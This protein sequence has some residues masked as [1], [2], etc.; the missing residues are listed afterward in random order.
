MSKRHR[1]CI[2][3]GAGLAG[4]A[5]AYRLARA[6]WRV[7][8]LEEQDRLGGRVMSH[9]FKEAPDLVCELGAEWIGTDHRAMRRLCREC[10]LRLV[11]HRYSFC[12][13][14]GDRRSRI[15][16]PG[17]WSGSRR[18]KRAF[19]AFGR[20]FTRYTEA[21]Q[22]E[23][24]QADW[25]MSLQGVGFPLEDLLRRDLMDS[26]DFGESIRLSSAYLA[27]T[28][29]FQSNR[30]DEMDFKIR[31][32][33]SSLVDALVASIRRRNIVRANAPVTRIE[34][35]ADGVAVYVQGQTARSMAQFCICTVPA[36]RLIGIEWR[37]A[38]P[39]DQANAARQL[40]Y[41]RIMKTA[42][43]YTERFWPRY[44][45]SGFSVFT[46]RVSDFCFDSTFRQ[47]GRQGILCSYAIGDKAD[48][49]AAEPNDQNVIKWI[50]EDVVSAVRPSRKLAI[51]PIAIKPQPWQR[52]PGIGGAYAFYR[53]GQWFTV[54]PT[55]E[56]PHGRVLFAGEHLSEPWQ[57]FMEGAVQ[58]GEAAADRLIAFA[59]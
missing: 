39:L 30:T 52:E 41:S 57:G 9:R 59:P 27:A 35:D 29:Y 12:F 32:G 7:E 47:R 58:T 31:D 5:A 50:T 46:S 33:N 24:N 53:P 23:L 54:R 55:L 26:T 6:R 14:D 8:V 3:V 56:R 48:D 25:W 36:H 44:K 49:L 10:G 18:A 16:R 51:A 19:K 21:E 40:Q 42:V 43:L 1:S 45:Q 17:A 22:R 38:L 28:E 13:W 34:Q 11:G 2:V 20:R 4:L 37:P 15:F